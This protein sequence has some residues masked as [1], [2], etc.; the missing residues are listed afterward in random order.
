MMAFTVGFIVCL[1]FCGS[2]VITFAF[3]EDIA[4]IAEKGWKI[5][6]AIIKNK[7][8]DAANGIKLR[9]EVKTFGA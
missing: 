2:A 8:E 6:A 9:T 3:G 4:A 5:I 1:A 7:Q